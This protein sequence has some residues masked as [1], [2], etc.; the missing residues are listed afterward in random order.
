MPFRM[1]KQIRRRG[2]LESQTTNIPGDIL[3]IGRGTDN[4]LHLED[5]SV[6]FRHARIEY[7]NGKYRLHDLT[8]G[9]GTYVG[10]IPITQKDLDPGD[11]IQ[12]GPYTLRLSLVHPTEPLTIT[13]EQEPSSHEDVSIHE[14]Y[15]LSTGRFSKTTLSLLLSGVVL[16][17][18]VWAIAF[19]QEAVFMPGTLSKAHE[20]YFQ[21]QSHD[22]SA[23]L[24][25]GKMA[26]TIQGCDECHPPWKPVWMPVSD[27][28]C[29]RCHKNPSHFLKNSGNSIPECAI[30]HIEH[31]GDPH[32]T[33]VSN[34]YCVQCHGDLKVKKGQLQFAGKIHDFSTDHPEFNL[35][36]GMRAATNP[37]RIPRTEWVDSTQIQLNHRL[38][39]NP[40]KAPQEKLVPH[41]GTK[42][43]NSQGDYV[44]L[45]CNSCHE[46]DEKWAY[47]KP[48]RYENH[49][50][51]CHGLDFDTRLPGET[52]QHGI[53]PVDIRTFLEGRFY[54][55]LTSGDQDNTESLATLKQ[56][57]GGGDSKR[58]F[59]MRQMVGEIEEKIYKNPTKQFCHKCHTA[60]ENSVGPNPITRMFTPVEHLPKIVDPD[61]PN[62][63]F[64]N[65]FFNHRSHFRD[66]RIGDKD[67]GCVLCH[68]EVG[69]STETKD[70]LMP[71]IASCRACHSTKGG[72]RAVC[73]E[74]HYYHEKHGQPEGIQQV[75]SENLPPSHRLENR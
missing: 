18:A 29:E 25:E 50:K 45:Q 67:K 39:L 20:G 66:P 16:A 57:P 73:G 49:C 43:R 74:C 3:T 10:Q 5:L 33:A 38:H 42:I 48:V 22:G 14:K 46:P 13:I 58:E 63:W 75:K 21:N 69:E 56:L 55:F 62:R 53:Q 64:Q 59:L 60:E 41:E 27:K 12:I 37:K 4:S 8:N 15:L 34:Q 54:A 61:I 65:S 70:V 28:T 40:D 68:G 17:G 51:Q 9:G 30:C 72:V 24:A 31:K 35:T 1:I 11:L 7:I 23:G 19:E 32:L 36:V 26:R 6:S 71:G 44:Q 47:M 2:E 52:I